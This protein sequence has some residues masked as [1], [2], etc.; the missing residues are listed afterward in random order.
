MTAVIEVG[1]GLAPVT[2]LRGL[3]L[4][5]PAASTLGRMAMNFR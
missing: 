4:D 5:T 3:S 1:T 2:L